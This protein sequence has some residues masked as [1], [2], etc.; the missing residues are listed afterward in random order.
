MSLGRRLLVVL[1]LAVTVLLAGFA[2][3]GFALSSWEGAR[4]EELRAVTRDVADELAAARA[5]TPADDPAQVARATLIG[6][7][8][9]RGG[10]CAKDGS[11][12]A[13]ARGARRNARAGGG[14]S[15]AQQEAVRHGCQTAASGVLD[16]TY[17]DPHEIAVV[18]TAGAVTG[19]IAWAAVFV[20]SDPPS[21]VGWRASALR[22]RRRV[23]R[24]R[25]GRRQRPRFVAQR[26]RRARS[27]HREARARP[28][29]ADRGAARDRARGHRA[30]GLV[31]GPSP[32]RR[33]RERGAPRA[34]L[35]Q[36]ERLAAL[37]RVAA[38]VAHEVRNPLASIK[39]RLDLAAAR[40]VAAPTRSA[41]TSRMPRGDRS[42]RSRGRLAAGGR[43]PRAK[44]RAAARLAPLVDARVAACAGAVAERGVSVSAPAR[45]RPW[46]TPMR[47]PARRQPPPQRRR[48]G[49][50]GGE[51]VARLRRD[52]D[53]VPRRR[54]R[55]GRRR[56]RALGRALRAVL[57][58]Q[59]GGDRA[60]ALHARAA[61]A[62]AHG[63]RR[64]LRTR[65]TTPDARHAV[66][67]ARG[68]RHER[69]RGGI[70]LIVDDERSVAR[71]ARRAR[72]ARWASRARGRARRRARAARGGRRRLRAARHPPQG[73]RR[74]RVPARAARG[75]P[76]RCR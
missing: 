15:S 47:W 12:V 4:L 25:H 31:D 27:R 49:P 52:G 39:L 32:R 23:G 37:G 73:R 33:A 22:A 40:R 20:R 5:R 59:A 61:L 3:L 6:Q 60:R 76:A 36:N 21:G 13:V 7:P 72:C 30:C 2:T 16:A 11:L 75:A 28:A 44:A 14:L 55:R 58:D 42:P 43:A 26:G 1:A 62:E 45:R 51:V 69:T 8:Q 17:R 53:A 65:R 10:F 34:E 29:R 68:T 54:R 66:R 19:E 63:R 38:G 46:S 71:R 57:H 9:V 74:A 64:G 18:A 24:A 41:P 67:D 50:A 70:V 48:G 35:A 56:R